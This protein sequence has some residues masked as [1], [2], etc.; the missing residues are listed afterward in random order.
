MTVSTSSQAERDLV[1]RK[2]M[3]T[4]LFI[5]LFGVSIQVE[6]R[7]EN[8]LETMPE[9]KGRCR[10]K[11]QAGLFKKEVV[12]LRIIWHFSAEQWIFGKVGETIQPEK[13]PVSEIRVII[14]V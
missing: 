4:I 10:F 12:L 7:L 8:L 11:N 9:I 2:D 14:G 1:A 5:E 13:V 6:D 3:T